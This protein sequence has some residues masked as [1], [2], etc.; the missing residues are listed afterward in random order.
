MIKLVGGM[1][2]SVTLWK[3]VRMARC[4]SPTLACGITCAES[5]YSSLACMAGG[6]VGSKSTLSVV[7]AEN[8]F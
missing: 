5:R 6:A 2:K 7:F 1:K 4:T 3:V 8:I